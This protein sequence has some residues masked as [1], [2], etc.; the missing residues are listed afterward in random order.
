MAVEFEREFEVEQSPEEVWSFLIDPR[1]VVP[2][3]PGARILRR[4]DECTYAGEIGL[5][6]G[7]LGATFRGRLR[8]ERIDEDRREVEISGRGEDERG[9]A[10]VEMRLWSRLH[11]LEGG[12]TRIA[13][14]QRVD[15]SGRP[16][17]PGGDR[18]VQGLAK[19]MFGRFRRCVREELAGG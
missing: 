11:R 15:L 12:G 19:V 5:E 10:G 9:S 2:C 7:P 4:V 17:L 13:L 6:L 3:L 16:L 14:R 8:F 1:R 18:V